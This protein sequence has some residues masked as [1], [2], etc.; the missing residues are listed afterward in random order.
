MPIMKGPIVQIL[1]TH[2]QTQAKVTVDTL[3]QRHT[4]ERKRE[5]IAPKYTKTK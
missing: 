4:E 2:I 5:A 3:A 1:I